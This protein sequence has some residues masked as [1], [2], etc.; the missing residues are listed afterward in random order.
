MDDSAVPLELTSFVGR[1]DELRAI[2]AAL[3]SARL[4]TLVGP[5]GCGKTRLAIRGAR[6]A[7]GFEGVH[8]ADL[9]AIDDPAAVVES[10]AAALGVL[11]TAD[12]DA[13]GV[14]AGQVADRRLLLC[15]DNCEHVLAAAADVVGEL[16]RRCPR[17]TVLCTS[18][19]ALRVPGELAWQVPPMHRA[20]AVRLFAERA[21]GLGTAAT[22]PIIATA[23]ARMEGMPL[24]VELAAAWS[25]TLSPR[26]I[27][28][29]LDDRFRLLI[30]GPHGVAAR[31]Q[32][33]AASMAWSHGLLDESDRGL[34][35]R[36]GVFRG[37]FTAAAAQALCADEEPVAVL[38]G[39]RRLVEKS[40]LTADTGGA[41]TRFRMLETVR[42]YA[43]R[44][45]TA[46][47]TI[48]SVRDRHLEACLAL[49]GTLR[50]LIDAD[51]DAWRAG[52]AAEYENL[53][54]AV[55]WGLSREDPSAGR[56][57]AAELPWF[58]H[59]DRR[60]REGLELL[61]RAVELGADEPTPLQ[62]RL[63][64]GLALVADTHGPIAGDVAARAFAA[65][66]AVDEPR[67][68]C[69]ALTLAAID[70]LHD[71]LEAARDMAADARARAG[72][73]G[74][75]FVHDSATVLMGIVCHL[76]D[77]HRQAAVL[78]EDGLR[79]LVP[80]GDRE[81]ASTACCLLA[82]S[83]AHGGDLP[84]AAGL[85]REALALAEPLADYHRVGTARVALTRV[86]LWAG[87]I[88]EAWA[89]VDPM[90]RI[91]EGVDPPPFIPGLFGC[92]GDLHRSVGDAEQAVR[93]Y[94]RDLANPGGFP[95]HLLAP[96]SRLGLARALREPAAPA[97]AEHAALAMRAGREL[98]MPGLVADAFEVAGLLAD[99]PKRAEDAHHEALALRAEHGLRLGC[100][101][102][103]EHL[104]ALA[105][106]A[107]AA[108]EA[109][110]LLGACD[111]AR[112]AFGLP[113]RR[114]EASP[115]NA[116]REAGRSMTLEEA[117]AYARRARGT[118]ARPASGWASLTPTEVSV[119]ELAITG[120]TNPEIAGRLFMS[121]ATVK[122][123]LSHAYAK[124][125][126]A[127]RTQLGRVKPG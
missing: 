91:V 46:A 39:L 66:E 28:D 65:A 56:R 53:H 37:G 124:L 42:E 58:W 79:G 48:A 11:R 87:R 34:F 112:A 117:V 38:E 50:P 13:V 126:I 20:D 51:K 74:D 32:T 60:G 94:E 77:D 71:D 84:R 9:S 118:R 61:R 36:L 97:A 82:L 67:A 7:A 73:L 1:D 41:V 15:L 17:L 93:W 115:E 113:A 96:Q 101:S 24:A 102:S 8:W 80:R 86:A 119:V 47:G 5:G 127:N 26:E 2:D 108:V 110:R 104:A 81:V 44:R 76:R 16:L 52:V 64:T 107:G 19:E 33:L 49:T 103:L 29:G 3:A 43:E 68:A 55:T 116:A 85:A 70:R 72:R 25:G 12:R 31:H 40:L 69:L 89:A 75:G 95:E 21:R 98:G 78:L 27:L 92:V 22:D 6:A 10:V 23:C 35:E 14:V 59:S 114:G 88:E 120:M 90:L 57:L 109:A 106:D 54:A 30:R 121:R 4:V 100:V 122:T 99:D 83:V 123:H 62:A 125:G 105:E 18:R 111:R 45:L 63:L